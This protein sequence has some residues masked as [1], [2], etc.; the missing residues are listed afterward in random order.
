MATLGD[1]GHEATVTQQISIKLAHGGVIIHAEYDRRAQRAPQFQTFRPVKLDWQTSR[2]KPCRAQLRHPEQNAVGVRKT[3]TRICTQ[4]G[5]G[6]VLLVKQTPDCRS[7]AETWPLGLFRPE[8][9]ECQT[10]VAG[11]LLGPSS[12]ENTTSL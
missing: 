7:H 12:S 9:M 4:S 1:E 5:L 2:I 6:K 10:V 8:A 11:G 3:A